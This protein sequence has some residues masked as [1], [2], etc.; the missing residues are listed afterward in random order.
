MVKARDKIVEIVD[1]LEKPGWSLTHEGDDCFMY[2]LQIDEYPT[3]SL[4]RTVVINVSLDKAKEF[5]KNHDNLQKID[6]KIK[7]F[8]ITKELGAQTYLLYQIVEGNMVVSDRDMLLC[9][10]MVDMTDGSLFNINFSV[11]DESVPEK[12]LCVRSAVNHSIH[13]SKRDENSI[14]L[15]SFLNFDP[16]GSIPI[17]FINQVT[18]LQFDKYVY[19]KKYIE[20][21]E[22]SK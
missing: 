17:M 6:K 5:F 8:E 4:K 3:K 22:D 9:S 1:H 7:H 16:K 15:T 12:P 18:G 19:M 21:L 14:N 2:E 20:E 13:I 10:Q 11:E